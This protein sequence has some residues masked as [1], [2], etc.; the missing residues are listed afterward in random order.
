MRRFIL[1]LVLMALVVARPTTAQ[2]EFST[3]GVRV[4]GE[5][6][7]TVWLR[8]CFKLTNHLTYHYAGRGDGFYGRGSFRAFADEQRALGF[9]GCRVL[10]ENAG[11]EPCDEEDGTP[12][13]CMFGSEPR[14]QG[15]WDVEA[16]RRGG[17]PTAMHGIARNVL[18]ELFAYSEET[19]F[20]FEVVVIA[21]LKHD[22]VEVGQQTH[23]VR[24]TLAEGYRLQRK[25]PRANIVMSTI[26]EWNAN[27]RPQWTL[28][29]VNMLATRADRCKRPDGTTV[30]A[31]T[32]PPGFE[33]EQWPNGPLIVDGGGGNTFDFDVG[34]EPGKYD[35]GAVHPTRD[36]DWREFPT[37]AQVAQLERDS[38]GMPWGVT[39]YM[40]LRYEGGLPDSAYRK[41]GW[42]RDC[43]GVIGVAERA[44]AK[45]AAWIVIHDEKG[46][47]SVVGWPRPETC[48]DRWAREHLA[49]ELP[50]PPPPPP[51]PPPPAG[52]RAELKGPDLDGRYSVTLVLPGWPRIVQGIDDS[53]VVN[54]RYEIALPF[55]MRLYAADSFIGLDQ[56]D[57]GEFAI[58]IDDA[59][60]GMEGYQRSLH[61]PPRAGYDAFEPQYR[62]LSTDRLMVYVTAR[63]T[64]ASTR[65]G[66]WEAR[67]H[68]AGYVYGYRLEVP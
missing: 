32:C 56:G 21:T 31:H 45:G 36:D 14:D 49:G 61:L 35:L 29:E 67:P 2:V 46:V 16:L 57:V 24:Q 42:T 15:A 18:E 11:W 39:E 4:R 6:V 12:E 19:G 43:A 41:G 30:I 37:D 34:P 62:A 17:R 53:S 22:D 38:R 63:V 52:A 60:S 54:E 47:E 3:D 26:N 23:V 64:G 58:E 5:L 1:T 33:P 44:A 48:I 40:Y 28:G 8:S 20:I 55:R 7:E 13:N 51:Q 65:T 27:A 10:L 25:Y 50:R 66:R 9:M 68:F 59:R